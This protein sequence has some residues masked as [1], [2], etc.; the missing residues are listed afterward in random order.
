LNI[1]KFFI[2]GCIIAAGFFAACGDDSTSPPPSAGVEFKDLTSE[3]D[4]LFNL[5]LSYNKRSTA[6]LDKLLD[7]DF[8]FLF[9]TQDVIQNGTPANWP[10][11]LELD[12][13][14]NIFDPSLPGD[15]RVIAIDVR[16]HYS[17][18][19]WLEEPPRGSHPGES[20]WTKTATY[21]C[22]INRADG[23]EY[24]AMGTLALFKI[25]WDDDAGHWRLVSWFDDVGTAATG[26]PGGPAVEY[27]S[28]GYVKFR[29][30]PGS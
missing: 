21:D 22:V 28:W 25:R 3:D 16:L 20:W 23:I 15:A 6:Q 12:A 24:R 5:A 27:V 30:A 2:A 19:G 9:S 29:Y 14:R 10:R 17:S 1:R 7:E 4:V 18:G 26:S 13:A 11:T 8:I